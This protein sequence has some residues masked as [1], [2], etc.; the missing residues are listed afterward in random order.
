MHQR[1]NST[2]M[3]VLAV[4]TFL[5]TIINT[6]LAQ[7][8][9]TIAVETKDNALVLQTDRDNRL[10]IVH[11]GK[12]LN[13]TQEYA[14]VIQQYNGNRDGI[15]AYTPAGTYNLAEPAIQV[16][17]ADG[18]NSLELKYVS[19]NTKKIDDNTTLTSVVLR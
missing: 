10:N 1:M 11:F 8:P 9:T 5:F 12:R 16:T 18:N 4:C 15:N 3:K 13:N 2:G 19:D 7:A 6:T 17:H 14:A